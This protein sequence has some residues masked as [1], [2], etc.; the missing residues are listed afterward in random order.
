ME[1]RAALGVV[2][3]TVMGAY[4]QMRRGNGTVLA[5]FDSTEVGPQLDQHLANAMW[6][7]ALAYQ[8]ITVLLL[9]TKDCQY[10]LLLRLQKIII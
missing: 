10:F 1:V 7:V 5:T 2:G 6:A 8:F 4:Y 3:A 9:L